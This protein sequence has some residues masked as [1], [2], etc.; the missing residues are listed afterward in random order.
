MEK[1]KGF[2]DIL[3]KRFHNLGKGI[4]KQSEEDVGD[5]EEKKENIKTENADVKP[6]EEKPK[7]E[8][9]P[10]KEE[11]RPQTKPN[12]ETKEVNGG[13]EETNTKVDNAK[14]QDAKADDVKAENAKVANAE[15]ENAN[16]V[17]KE[18][19]AVQPSPSSDDNANDNVSPDSNS[20]V[21]NENLQSVSQEENKEIK[22]G[23][24]VNADTAS[25]H[26]EEGEEKK[27]EKEND[28]TKGKEVAP[29]TDSVSDNKEQE[30]SQEGDIRKAVKE[31]IDSEIKEMFNGLQE[32]FKDI[33]N[34]ITK[35][36][37]KLD[38]M[39]KHI[40][41]NSLDI[42]SLQED[43]EHAIAKR[44]EERA[45]REKEEN[46]KQKT[47]SEEDE[48]T[49][50]ASP[51]DMDNNPSDEENDASD[52][53]VS[54][55]NDMDEND[56]ENEIEG[57]PSDF[58]EENDEDGNN[59][60]EEDEDESESD[61]KKENKETVK[62]DNKGADKSGDKKTEDK[63][64]KPDKS[65]RPA[66]PKTDASKEKFVI[67]ADFNV[68]SYEVVMER[69]QTLTGKLN[70]TLINAGKM[71]DNLKVTLEQVRMENQNM[72]D[73]AI[74]MQKVLKDF[75]EM[76]DKSMELNDKI[77]RIV[78]YAKDIFQ[79]EY[80]EMM[81]TTATAAS[82]QF[83]NDSKAKYEELFDKAIKNFKQFSEAAMGWQKE[84]EG[85]S[86][87]K[88][89]MVSKVSLISPIMLGFVIILQL[90]IIFGKH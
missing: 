80:A 68:D 42:K 35:S 79:K 63:K 54:S 18:G 48:D 40:S 44:A 70:T 78:T 38:A 86:N 13:N 2:S 57:E 45:K 6:K 73:I 58:V 4:L 21:E 84:I 14:I 75:T 19:D 69:M 37:A 66:G 33:G 55:E 20:D 90:Y 27:M 28:K 31:S 15:A 83:L 81:Y 72:A 17:A 76:Q 16:H 65:A 82:S 9:K 24:K 43:K 1:T 30:K 71:D 87:K 88:L 53:R 59:A 8:A 10:K 25:S 62:S 60:S 56:F 85:K 3:M 47:Q 39:Q 12:V 22:T 23:D 51:E 26:E 32:L 67:P 7:K 50:N 29:K 89:D 36:N 34:E 52:D 61:E 5:A 46:K 77:T 64:N 49:N 74:R 41:Q 11:V